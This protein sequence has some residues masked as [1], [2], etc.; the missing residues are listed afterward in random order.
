M[1]VKSIQINIPDEDIR[2][3]RKVTDIFCRVRKINNLITVLLGILI[4]IVSPDFIYSQKDTL[5]SKTYFINKTLPLY[6]FKLFLVGTDS[7]NNQ[8]EYKIEIS[9]G[10][11]NLQTLIVSPMDNGPFVRLDDS[12]IDV[13]FDGYNDLLISSFSGEAGKNQFYD[14]WLFD[15]DSAKFIFS[16][17]F[18]GFCNIMVN[19]SLKIL[20][21]YLFNGCASQCYTMH[22]YKLI[23]N[24]PVLIK[25]EDQFYDLQT[26]VLRRFIE[27]YKDGKLISKKE[28]NA[29]EK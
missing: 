19:D 23:N 4:L 29:I 26:G 16:E 18:S 14:C 3:L 20:Y 12:L 7:I 27:S 5:S 9:T 24:K 6:E 25:R 22:T 13:N 8:P 17:N 2:D 28:V 11:T 21:D 1:K 15:V 10:K